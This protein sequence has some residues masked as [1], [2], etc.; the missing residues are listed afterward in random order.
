MRS[1]REALRSTLSSLGPG[2]TELACHP[3]LG[4][5]SGSIYAGER[6][7]EVATLCDP[8]VRAV[9]DASDIRLCS[10]GDVGTDRE[11]ATE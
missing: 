6:D 9:I 3:G 1:A 8:S 11:G 5:E 4:D 10:F 2:T 7:V